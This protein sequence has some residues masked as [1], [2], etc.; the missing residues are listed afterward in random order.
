MTKLHGI[1][2]ISAAVLLATS[3]AAAGDVIW[4]DFSFSTKQILR[5]AADGSGSASE[6]FA[7]ANT[8]AKPIASKRSSNIT[9]PWR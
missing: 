7:I 6:L 1:L 9:R 2:L 5:G 3:P 8:P 4:T